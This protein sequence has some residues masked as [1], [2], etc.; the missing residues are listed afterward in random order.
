[1][2]KDGIGTLGCG[3][4]TICVGRSIPGSLGT[5]AVNEVAWKAQRIDGAERGLRFIPTDFPAHL[6]RHAAQKQK[7]GFQTCNDFFLVG[8]HLFPRQESIP[9][10]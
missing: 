9:Q 4:R 1:M 3:N 7:P 2:L 6:G 5:P 10:G 8:R